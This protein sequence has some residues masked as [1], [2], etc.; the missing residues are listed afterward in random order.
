MSKRIIVIDVIVLV[1]YILSAFPAITGVPAHEWISIVGTVILLVHC[2]ARGII[3][4]RSSRSPKSALPARQPLDAG[5]SPTPQIGQAGR[6][7]RTILNVLITGAL[8]ICFVSGIMV[9]GTV[10]PAFGIFAT[11]YYFWD[12]LHAISAKVLLALLLIHVVINIPVIL[13]LVRRR[14]ETRRSK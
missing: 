7:W 9:S 11:G 12:P 2:A 6:A 14:R 4:V 1:A 8:A 5:V 13:A 3:A 10:L